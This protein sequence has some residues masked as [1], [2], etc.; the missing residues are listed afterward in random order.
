MAMESN[1]WSN[2]TTGNKT[3]IL[4]TRAFL[5]FN[6]TSCLLPM[7]PDSKRRYDDCD[8][9]F[10]DMEAPTTKKAKTITQV[11]TQSKR[12][13][14]ETANYKKLKT[15]LDNWALFRQRMR[16]HDIPDDDLQGRL[17][18]YY[19]KMRPRGGILPIVYSAKK[20][21]PKGRVYAEGPSYQSFPREIRH[22]LAYE[23]YYDLDIVKSAPTIVYQQYSQHVNLPVLGRY[24]QSE[25]SGRDMLTEVAIAISRVTPSA[26]PRRCCE[27]AKGMMLVPLNGGTGEQSGIRYQV[28]DFLPGWFFDYEAECVAIQNYIREAEPALVER[29]EKRKVEEKKWNVL[30]AAIEHL[31][32]RAESTIMWEVENILVEWKWIQDGYASPIHDG[33]QVLRRFVD[34]HRK[35]DSLDLLSKR[36]EDK[37]GFR[38]QFKFKEFDLAWTD[39]VETEDMKDRVLRPHGTKHY[40]VAQELLSSLVGR[41]KKRRFGKAV[42]FF[43]LQKNGLW[44][45]SEN[46]LVDDMLIRVFGMNIHVSRAKE[47][48]DPFTSDMGHAEKIVKCALKFIPEPDGM[49]DWHRSVVQGPRGKVV[50]KNGYYDGDLGEFC[51]NMDGIDCM[52]R[53]ERNYER[54][55]PDMIQDVKD[56][57]LIP[58]LGPETCETY[59]CFMLVMARALFGKRGKYSLTFVGKRNRGKTLLFNALTH[60]MGDYAKVFESGVIMDG[61]STGCAERDNNVFIQV[62]G[63]RLAF[64]DESPDKDANERAVKAWQSISLMPKIARG[65]GEAAQS[66]YNFSLLVL[67]GNK[68]PRMLEAAQKNI[69]L[70]AKYEFVSKGQLEANAAK[71]F[72][73][74]NLV[75][76]R[77][78]MEHYIYSEGKATALLEILFT[79]YHENKDQDF[80]WEDFPDVMEWRDQEVGTSDNTRWMQC[81]HMS[82]NPDDEVS[83]ST[84]VATFRRKEIRMTVNQLEEEIKEDLMDKTG[85]NPK[86]LSSY[87]R[88]TAGGRYWV[89][90]HLRAVDTT[91]DDM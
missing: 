90:K 68:L 71:Q 30:G 78:E 33:I 72:P 5:A 64:T 44:T 54:A 58:I 18:I 59:R 39:V 34:L 40:E 74:D 13:L 31:Y 9:V 12:T 77:P 23:Q 29:I 87:K 1:A 66:V 10:A 21:N 67:N 15:I 49:E 42:N 53:I 6:F 41:V 47:G 2:T 56:K 24:T 91:D 38:V 60:A 28:Q 43:Y 25:D 37:T 76:A 85:L 55:S 88:G 17:M 32:E 3:M 81:F 82:T 14:K 8:P 45:Q 65:C 57:L 35:S 75:L 11:N 36:I 69:P 26:D 27:M 63:R 52:L 46:A 48:S 51:Y 79:T 16:K 20:N 83:H 19:Q 61:H 7:A 70:R 22:T 80:E 89:M 62:Q 50:M 4:W 73:A 84:I 86:T